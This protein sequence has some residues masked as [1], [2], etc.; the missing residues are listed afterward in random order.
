M[1]NGLGQHEITLLL[2]VCR[3]QASLIRDPN[4]ARPCSAVWQRPKPPTNLLAGCPAFAVL[5][6]VWRNVVELVSI[7]VL[8]MCSSDRPE[9]EGIFHSHLSVCV[10]Q[11]APGRQRWQR[12]DYAPV[13][14]E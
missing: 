3:E 1:E 11:P 7:T 4:P 5:R 2:P 12:A 6:P 8:G 13:S 10:R 9:Y 14:P